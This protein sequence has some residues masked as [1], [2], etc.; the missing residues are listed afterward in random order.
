MCHSGRHGTHGA[1]RAF[2]RIEERQ[3]RRRERIRLLGHDEMT[4]VLDDP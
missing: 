2:R 1:V 3:E 4:R